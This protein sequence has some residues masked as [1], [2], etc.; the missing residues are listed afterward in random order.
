[1]IANS[2]H[3]HGLVVQPP[4]MLVLGFVVGREAHE[5]VWRCVATEHGLPAPRVV[6]LRHQDA[7]LGR[8]QVVII[9]EMRRLCVLFFVVS[10][11]SFL[12]EMVRQ[13]LRHIR[14]HKEI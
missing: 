11:Y 2:P 7:N 9:I 6:G 14:T 1:M 3:L 13:P 8:G 5:S 4:Q 12:G 10:C